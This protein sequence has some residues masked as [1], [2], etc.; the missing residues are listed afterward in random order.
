LFDGIRGGGELINSK[1]LTV[2]SCFKNPSL[3]EELLSMVNS[4]GTPT[5]GV[6]EM[7]LVSGRGGWGDIVLEDDSESNTSRFSSF[8]WPD[9]A[10]CSGLVSSINNS[11]LSTIEWGLCAEVLLI[12]LLLWLLILKC[13]HLTKVYF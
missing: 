1:S 9:V 4:S 10:S 12:W 6:A 5:V 11:V 3:A 2:S 7:M 13:P 8:V